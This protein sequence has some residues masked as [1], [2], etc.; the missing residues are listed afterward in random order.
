MYFVVDGGSRGRQTDS[1]IVLDQNQ[2]KSADPVTYDDKGEIIPITRRF[3]T[4]KTDIRYSLSK[5]DFSIAPPVSADVY[6]KDIGYDIAPPIPESVLQANGVAPSRISME[7]FANQ[8]SPVWNNIAYDDEA[9][10]KSIT[11]NTHE[12]MMRA[13]KVV[14]VS[15]DVESRVEK[16][17]PDLRN[18]KKKE[19]TPIL[20]AAIDRLKTDLRQ[21]LNGFKGQKFAFSANG[22]VLDAKLYSTGINEVLDQITQEKAN[23]LYTTEEIFRNA[24]YLYSTP[25]YDGDPNVYRWNYFY[26]PVKIG[27][28]TVGVRIAVRD[29]AKQGESQIYNWSIKKDASLGGVRD[30]S[31]NRKS[32]DTSS[33]ASNNNILDGKPVVN[34]EE[35]EGAARRKP[36][37]QADSVSHLQYK[38]GSLPEGKKPVREYS[39]SI[40]RS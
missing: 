28:E 29:M 16:S 5:K 34:T 30:D 1:L 7:E 12:D 22:K 40:G 20:K 10:K 19:R 35:S 21:F 15:E 27:S 39:P 3:D 6:G 38:Y 9:K 31:Q 25:D 24:Q 13:G 17:Y 32:H 4:G 26:T 18:V 23:M 14:V 37:G 11:R 8:E 2:V 33:D 36:T